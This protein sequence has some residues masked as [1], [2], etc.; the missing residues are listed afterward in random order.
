MAGR[1][2]P[3]LAFIDV[4]LETKMA[5]VVPAELKQSHRIRESYDQCLPDREFH[6]WGWNPGQSLFLDKK[7]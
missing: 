1:I 6:G 5:C 2:A 4:I 3:Q 7:T